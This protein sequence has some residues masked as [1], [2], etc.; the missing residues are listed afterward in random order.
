MLP[1]GGNVQLDCIGEPGPFRLAWLV[2]N[3][4]RCIAREFFA[5]R[6]DEEQDRTHI[7]FDHAKHGP[8]MGTFKALKGDMSGVYELRPTRQTT[9]FCFRYRDTFVITNGCWKRKDVVDAIHKRRARDL[10]LM[11]LEALT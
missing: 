8:P 2:D 4:G 11:F 9:Y 3:D 7:C 5:S 10:K 6:T 1:L